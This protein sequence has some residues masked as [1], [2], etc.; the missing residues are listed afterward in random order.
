MAISVKIDGMS[1]VMNMLKKYSNAESKLS[2]GIEKGCMIVEGEAKVLCPVSTEET[3][4][5][6][7]H[8]E[9][10][11]SITHE[12]NKNTGA[13][14]TN[15]EYGIYV[16]LGTYKMAAQPFLVPALLSKK[17]EVVQ[18]IKDEVTG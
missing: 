17:D 1:N 18:A 13:V 2:R 12:V 5:G 8:G 16:E 6:G 10:R 11:D 4:P 14:G 7:P 15:K 9:L 3:R